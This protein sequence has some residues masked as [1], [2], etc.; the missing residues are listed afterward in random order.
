LRKHPPIRNRSHSSLSAS[1]FAIIQGTTGC[2][3][4]FSDLVNFAR[5]GGLFPRL[6][7][8]EGDLDRASRSAF[9]KLLAR[10]DQCAIGSCRFAING[11][12]HNRR[13]YVYQIKR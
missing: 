9:S 1:A 5:E 7:P 10:Y 13:F 6:I 4:E 11:K 12:G 3:V 2:S 8:E